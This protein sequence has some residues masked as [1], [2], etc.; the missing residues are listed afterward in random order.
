VLIVFHPFS[1]SLEQLNGQHQ[2]MTSWK[3]W[4]R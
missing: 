3:Y 1:S 2:P 4:E